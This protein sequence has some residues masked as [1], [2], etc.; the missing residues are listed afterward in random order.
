MSVI[1]V[2]WQTAKS[3]LDR[4]DSCQREISDL[5][6]SLRGI[7]SNRCMTGGNYSAVY[8]AMDKAISEMEDEKENIKKLKNGLAEILKA[9]DACEMRV[10]GQIRGDT[11]EE[12]N[13]TTGSEGTSNKPFRWKQSDSWKVVK[14]F[15]ILGN[16]ASAVHTTCTNGWSLK[17]AADVGQNL[18]NIAGSV[19]GTLAKGGAGAGDWVRELTGIKDGLDGLNTSNFGS[20]FKSSLGKQLGKDLSF[21]GAQNTGDKV[22]VGAKWVGHALTF[23]KNG[24][25]NYEEF[26]GVTGRMITETAIETAVDIGVGVVTKAAVSAGIATICTAMGLEVAAP[27]ALIGVGAVGVTWVA[28][29]T[30]K[31][32]TGGKDIAE[33]MSDL[34]CD[35]F[36]RENIF[37]ANQMKQG[38]V[39]GVGSVAAKGAGTV[40]NGV[41]AVTN[42][43]E[44]GIHKVKEGFGSIA[45]W[46][47]E[48]FSFA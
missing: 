9:Y 18:S 25:E 4:Y 42:V 17:T 24:I 34:V 1:S 45:E 30:C 37:S 44:D 33:T 36:S 7:R 40:A 10:S 6:A 26:G 39:M 20:T 15:G 43:I 19:G 31:W 12:V 29:E 14:Q 41:K 13:V 3:A 28:N 46:G 27:A 47:G 38:A 35:I 5:I 11:L 21:K 23:L 22:K 16:V 32:L 48:V 8:R 2:K